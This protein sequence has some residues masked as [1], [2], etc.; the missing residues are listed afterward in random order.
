MENK[1]VKILIRYARASVVQLQC[2][3]ID[4][5]LYVYM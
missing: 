5:Q 4:K 2:Y 1:F 3:K